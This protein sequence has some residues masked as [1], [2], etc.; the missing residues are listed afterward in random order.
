MCDWPINLTAFAD[1]RL[2]C[3]KQTSFH[4][5]ISLMIRFL[6]PWPKIKLLPTPLLH[7]SQ[8]HLLFSSTL[9][10]KLQPNITFVFLYSSSNLWLPTLISIILSSHIDFPCS[11]PSRSSVLHTVTPEANM[12][13]AVW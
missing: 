7:T 4:S 3:L 12:L 5:T 8:G 6:Q 10:F 2:A 1:E 9:S 13:V 11:L